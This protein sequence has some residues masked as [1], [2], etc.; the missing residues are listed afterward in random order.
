MDANPYQSPTAANGVRGI[1][2]LDWCGYVSL[3]LALLV[4]FVVAWDD[5]SE[6]W[7]VLPRLPMGNWYFNVSFTIAVFVFTV[8][9]VPFGAAGLCSRARRLALAGLLLGTIGSLV[10]FYTKFFPV[11]MH[12]LR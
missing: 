12:Y 9:S 5:V 8:L 6:H 2:D 7:Q 1:A 11:L 4:P 3:P 10:M